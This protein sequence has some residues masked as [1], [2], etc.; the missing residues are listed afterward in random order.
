MQEG[1]FSMPLGMFRLT[2]DL[3]ESADRP[4]RTNQDNTFSSFSHHSIFL[5]LWMVRFTTSSFLIRSEH[6]ESKNFEERKNR[7]K[8]AEVFQESK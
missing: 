5:F 4:R 3:C 7:R 2:S 6:W 8:K 1:T